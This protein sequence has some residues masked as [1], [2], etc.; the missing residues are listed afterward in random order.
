MRIDLPANRIRLEY[1][2]WLASQAA[3]FTLRQVYQGIPIIGLAGGIGSGKSFVARLFGVLGCTFIDSDSQVHAAYR[4]PEVQ[5][6]LKQWW[7]EEVFDAYGGVNRAAVARRVFHDAVQRKQ[8]E[9]LLH[10]RVAEARDAAMARAVSTASNQRQPVAFVWDTPLIFEAGLRDRC[11]AVI[12][13]E[14][15]RELRLQRV[16]RSRG[17]SDD[18]LATRENLQWPLD[19]K[20][21]LSDDILTN[22]AEAEDLRNQVR[23]ALSRIVTRLSR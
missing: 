20:K 21:N 14:A 23:Q 13:V 8:L 2:F 5:K 17:W 3:C 16:S 9:S 4:D 12:F 22:T 19:K 6:T 18:E 10:P 1:S 15:P 11:D 7:G